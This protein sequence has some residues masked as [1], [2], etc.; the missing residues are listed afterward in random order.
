[1][2][3]SEQGYIALTVN[4]KNKIEI[5]RRFGYDSGKHHGPVYSLW[6]NPAHMKNFISIGDWSVKIWHDDLP[7]PIMQTRYHSS[8]L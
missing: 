4:K 6:P 7:T 3:G 1:M 2:I 5:T 8:Y